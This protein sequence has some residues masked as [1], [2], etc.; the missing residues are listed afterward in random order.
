MTTEDTKEEAEA[1][2]ATN[3]KNTEEEALLTQAEIDQ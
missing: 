2:V 1:E 3:I